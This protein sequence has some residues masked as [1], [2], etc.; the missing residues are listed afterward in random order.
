MIT[1]FRSQDL[2]YLVD[3]GYANPNNDENW[4]KDNCKHDSKALFF[5][6]QVLHETMF[7][8]IAAATTSKQAWTTLKTKFQG[9]AK[10]IALKL[11]TLRH[12]FEILH[13]KSGDSVQDFVTRM[14]TVVNQMKTYGYLISDQ[15]VVAKVLRSLTP[16][17]DHVV[18]AIEESK[19]LTKLTI[20]VKRFFAST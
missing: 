8:Q 2:W 14:L 20:D 10:V 7:S 18:A 5:I 9:S 6:Q 1:R 13:M 11:Q 12:E 15:N 16:R 19:D 4:L 3:K 17:F